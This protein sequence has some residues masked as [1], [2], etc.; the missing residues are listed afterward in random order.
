MSSRMSHKAAR[1]FF[2]SGSSPEAAR[3]VGALPEIVEIAA[4]RLI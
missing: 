2:Q 4:G 1:E 3:T